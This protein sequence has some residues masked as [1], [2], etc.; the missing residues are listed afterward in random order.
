MWPSHA[1]RGR[2]KTT[3]CS[4]TL[5]RCMKRLNSD[6]LLHDL[7][8]VPWHVI[9]NLD[10]VDDALHTFEV[11]LTEVW[12]THAP[13]KRR[14]RRRKATPWITQ[15]ALTHIMRRKKLYRRFQ[16]QPGSET[17]MAYKQARNY[18][19]S[20]IRTAKRTFLLSTA[21]DSRNF[22]QTISRCTG[23][24]KKQRVEPPWP[25]SSPAICKLT[26]NAVN[27]S[28]V[29][30]VNNIT[31]TFPPASC[32]PPSD[33]CN[34][35]TACFSLQRVTCTDVIAAVE[36]LSSPATSTMDKIALRLLKVS[37][38][39][40][41]QPLA[42]IFNVSISTGVFPAS[43]KLLKWCLCTNKAI[44]PTT[45]ATGLFRCCHCCPRSWSISCIAR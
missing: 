15:E 26:A 44:V 12:D 14:Q 23:L 28:F 34:D 1:G 24:G 9:T 33:G 27:K 32:K 2:G 22:W 7:S 39:A 4:Y 17:W 5:Y 25:R 42:D 36:A 19:T 29:T 13:W 20:V 35:S 45:T 3:Y 6:S 41:K 10:T 21:S 43:W 11:L 40:I 37:L 30:A 38:P 16:Q 31:S 8:L 18:A